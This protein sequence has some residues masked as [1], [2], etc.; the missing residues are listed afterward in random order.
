MSENGTPG[1][2]TILTASPCFLGFGLLSLEE[3]IYFPIPSTGVIST[4]YTVLCFFRKILSTR[5]KS[6]SFDIK[7]YTGTENGISLLGLL[8]LEELIS[9]PIPSTGGNPP[10]DRFMALFRQAL[11]TLLDSSRQT[12]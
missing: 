5:F 8:R 1:Q 9:F 7:R 12:P 2:Q 4:G 10:A 3:L 11:Q 6:V